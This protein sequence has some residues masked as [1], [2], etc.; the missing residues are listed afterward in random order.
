MFY[1]EDNTFPA[2]PICGLTIWKCLL[3]SMWAE[4]ALRH[5]KMSESHC[6]SWR[7]ERLPGAPRPCGPE[8]RWGG[9]HLAVQGNLKTKSHIAAHLELRELNPH[10][11]TQ[12][13]AISRFTQTAH[14]D[15]RVLDLLYLI[16]R[17][18]PRH[19]GMPSASKTSPLCWPPP[20]SETGPR[21]G[22]NLGGV[23]WLCICSQ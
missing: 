11:R 23:T 9:D 20:R 16:T 22:E 8:E 12:P 3:F 5:Q 21:L 17:R 4:V 1:I 14:L 2:L 15:Q 13:G 7:S 19:G 10:C 6:A 18:T